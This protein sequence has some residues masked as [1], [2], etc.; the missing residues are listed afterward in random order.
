[1]HWSTISS[2]IGIE[3]IYLGNFTKK[4]GNMYTL[5]INYNYEKP[6]IPIFQ[7]IVSVAIQNDAK[8]YNFCILSNHKVVINVGHVRDKI[9]QI[10]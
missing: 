5:K 2:F 8:S 3:I 4:K 1:M 10:I 6:F 7:W 9:V